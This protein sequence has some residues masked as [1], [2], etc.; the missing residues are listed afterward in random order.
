MSST[1]TLRK[2]I[3]ILQP[4]FQKIVGKATL[5]NSFYGVTISAGSDGEESACN[6]GDPGAIPGSGR[7]PGRGNGNPL[8]YSCLENPIDREA[9]RVI[10]HGV[11][12]LDRTERLTHMHT[13]SHHPKTGKV[14]IRENQEELYS[15]CTRRQKSPTK[16]YLIKPNKL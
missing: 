3:A 15:S 2:I 9:W 13:S 5:P 10:V 11:A 4:L 7:P 8:Q 12:E 6:A 1:R 14:S 16:Y